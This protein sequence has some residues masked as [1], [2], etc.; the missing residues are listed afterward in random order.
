M[1]KTFS[2]IA[3]VAFGNNVHKN[4]SVPM[5]MLQPSIYRAHFRTSKK[6][7]EKD[8]LAGWLPVQL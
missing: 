6:K 4:V 1:V 8:V 5:Q 3:M 2:N 7:L